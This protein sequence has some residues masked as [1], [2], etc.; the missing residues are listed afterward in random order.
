MVDCLTQMYQIITLLNTCHIIHIKSAI[1]QPGK[2]VR[3][4]YLRAQHLTLVKTQSA[5]QDARMK[6]NIIYGL[7]ISLFKSTFNKFVTLYFKYVS[8]LWQKVFFDNKRTILFT[9]FSTPVSALARFETSNFG[10]WVECSATEL[11]MM[12]SLLHQGLSYNCKMARFKPRN[13]G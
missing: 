1:W 7:K 9:I 11:V 6:L 2:Q 8:L 10:Y 12:V 3:L 4:T 13:L 5:N